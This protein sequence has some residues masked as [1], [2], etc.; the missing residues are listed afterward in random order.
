MAKNDFD[1]DWDDPFG[2]EFDLDMD[3][4]MDPYAKKGFLGGV[5]SGFLSGVVDETVGSGPARMRTL[6]TI[7]PS[8]FSNALDR[9]SYAATK[10]EE[11]KTDFKE[12]NYESVKSLQS[13]ARSIGEKARNKG[14]GK[15]ADQLD[16]FSEKDFSSWEKYDY[17]SGPTVPTMEQTDEY[18]VSR[19]IEESMDSQEGVMFRLGDS[20][21]E[22]SATV[23]GMLNGAIG[24]GNRQLVS[25]DSGVKQLI[26]FQRSIQFKMDQAKVNLM[27]K[28]YVADIKFYKFMEKG[29][30]TEIS[31]LKKIVINSNKSDYEKTSHLTASKAFMRNRLFNT[32]G[33]RVGGLSGLL[34]DRFGAD[35]RKGTYGDIEGILGSFAEVLEMSDDMPI[36]KGMLG[37]M[38]GKHLAGALINN[39]PYYFERGGGKEWIDKLAEKNPE[40]AEAFKERYSQV[41]NA[42]NKI[43]YMANNATGLFNYMAED[44]QPI[45]EMKYLDYED[46]LD[47]LPADKK[48]TPR[49]LWE[50]QNAVGNRAKAGINN[51][52]AEMTKAKGT[53][54]TLARRNVKDLNQPG[55]WKEMN[56]IT[57]NEVLPGLLGRIHQSVEGIRTGE[58]GEAISYSYMRGQYMEEGDRKTAVAADL[59]PYSDFSRY[60]SAALEFVDSVDPDKLL[61]ANARKAFA[62]QIAKDVDKEKGFN[63]FYYLG[64]IPGITGSVQNEIHTVIKRHFD[65]DDDG[66]EAFKQ[67]TGLDRVNFM[68]TMKTDIAQERLNQAGA[69]AQ[70]LKEIFPNVAERIDLLRSTGNEQL[71]RDIGV[72]Y[73]ENGVD[74]V[75]MDVFHNR[76]AQFMDNP[77]DPA[78]RGMGKN[79]TF[80]QKGKDFT[81]T[82]FTPKPNPYTEVENNSSVGITG[83]LNT[84]MAKLIDTINKMDKSITT[85]NV[86][87]LPNLSEYVTPLSNHLDTISSNTGK[88]ESLMV[89][90]LDIVKAGKLFS[91][92]QS[93]TEEK[94]EESAKSGFMNKMKQFLPTNIF[95]KGLDLVMKNQPIVLG[96]V[97]GA[98]G[99]NF[100]NNP[101]LAAGAIAGGALLGAVVQRW[102]KQDRQA[103]GDQPS[104]D[105][106]ILNEK[107]ETL[108]SSA[109]LKAGL[110]IDA[111]TKRV[112]NTW[113]EIR[114]PIFDT[115]EKIV[116]GIKDLAGKIFGA[117]G[118]AVVLNG[119]RQLKEA[120]IAAYNFVDPIGRIKS[121]MAM[122]KELIYQQ[123]VYVPGDKNPRLRAI[124]FKNRDYF[125]DDAGSYRPISGWNE[126]KGPV[127]D[128]EANELISQEEY[129]A[130]LITASGQKVRTVSAFAANTMSGVAGLA[131]TGFE[132]LMAKMGFQRPQ[133]QENPEGNK[134]GSKTSQMAGTEHRLDRIYALLSKQFGKG[135]DNDEI[136]SGLKGSFADRL[137]SLADKAAKAKE[138]KQ[139]K[140]NEAIQDIAAELKGDDK[141]PGEEKKQGLFSKLLGMFGSMGG[142]AM[143]FIRNPLGTLAGGILGSL[144]ASAG[145]LG[146]IGSLLF[147]GVLGIASPIFKLL[148]WGFTG[149]AKVISAS[150]MGG[151]GSLLGTGGGRGRGGILGGLGRQLMKLPTWGKVAGAAALA[152]GSVYAGSNLF[153]SEEEAEAD[154]FATESE[155]EPKPYYE[156]PKTGAEQAYLERQ[157]A[158]ETRDKENNESSLGSVGK[159]IADI[160]P[161]NWLAKKALGLFGMDV[162]KEQG[163]K[164]FS[165]DGKMFLSKQDRDT[166]E[167]QRDGV[168]APSSLTRDAKGTFSIQKQIRYA[169]YGLRKVDNNLAMRIDQLEQN[170]IPYVSIINNRGAFRDDAPVEKIV[171]QFAMGAG[172]ISYDQ[173]KTWFSARFKPIFLIYNVGISIAR[174]GDINEFDMSTSPDV[175]ATIDRLRTSVTTVEPFPLKVSVQIDPDTGIM[176]EYATN[177]RVQELMEELRKKF[178][179]DK[180]TLKL[181]TADEMRKKALSSEPRSSNPIVGAVQ[182]FFGRTAMEDQQRLLDEKFKTPKEVKE[183]DIS[184]LHS[185]TD[186]AMDPFTWARLS[187]YGNVDN[188]PWRVDAVLKLERYTENLYAVM[189]E[190]IKF[191]GHPKKVLELF[192]PMFRIEDP[193]AEDR[194]LDW[195][196]NRFLPVVSVY[197]KRCQLYRSGK[198]SRVWQQLSATNKVVIAR[199]L[200]EIRVFYNDNEVSIWDVTVGPFPNSVSGNAS[201][202]AEKFLKM[203]DIKATE[204]RLKEPEVEE[205]KSKTASERMATTKPNS[206][207][208]K[209]NTNR[210]FDRVYGTNRQ[211]ASG[212][213]S[214]GGGGSGMAM[215][216]NGSPSASNWSQSLGDQ[217]GGQFDGKWAAGFN[218]EYAKLAGEDK[219]IKFDPAEGERL[220]LNTMLK[221]GITDKKQIAL[222]LAMAKKETGNY[223]A[224]VENT[225]W[226]A[227]TLKK[228]FRNIPDM[229]TAQ[230]V[231]SLPPAERAMY[232]YGRAPKGPTLGNEKPEDGW[233]YRGRGLF[234]LTGKANYR[235][236][237]SETG[238]PVVEDP[239]LVSENPEVMAESAVRFL[240]N[241]KAMMDIG[242]SGNFETAVRGIN[243]GNAVPGTDERRQY[244][245]E[246]LQK[247]NSG[248]LSVPLTV[249]TQG[250]L[251]TPET[252]PS[253]P[254]NVT[255]G[256]TL[257]G[258]NP[259]SKDKLSEQLNAA[260]TTR[261]VSTAPSESGNKKTSAAV[262]NVKDIVEASDKP[263]KSE[264]KLPA[265]ATPAP[266]VPSTMAPPPAIAKPQGPTEVTLPEG[267]LNVKDEHM[268]GVM[269]SVVQTLDSLNK[270]LGQFN[271]NNN[272]VAL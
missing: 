271:R 74:K 133:S 201:S 98:V 97:L 203:L 142:L 192:K 83:E 137:N 269:T 108:L 130:G 73:T 169:Q 59:M 197:I 111:I 54:Y 149:L 211:I 167:D 183:I 170:L 165:D 37:S 25:I 231:A 84:T 92:K 223:S 245:Q 238:I 247:L 78:L 272:G 86:S 105:E 69:S 15:T 107:G 128:S 220:M 182:D 67:T 30:H 42:G 209:N 3:F 120:G 138:E 216:A 114:G 248:E 20:L 129:D 61:S 101:I 253:A 207:T 6:R 191:I 47:N 62:L 35:A 31:E 242:R 193:H 116:I 22:M 34:R 252:P 10:Y 71:L 94:Q 255:D 199:E 159:V 141:E 166:Y 260:D 196:E 11:L 205:E 33:N 229:A 180:S 249:E 230:K 262:P 226:S 5:T 76:F 265:V 135:V 225:N 152:G 208:I 122:G 90:L 49:A 173:A 91:R 251:E 206:D 81:G 48:P 161:Q 96:S 8:S 237:Q 136:D 24:A 100:I 239:K 19:S 12:Q 77:N 38:A 124:G 160:V 177:D 51:V 267:P 17:N 215:G 154:P 127:F 186:A 43:S 261:N 7:L 270:T 117:D 195:F 36:S 187:V 233:L 109:K 2:G 174:L 89:E 4:D 184:D 145:R 88:M 146:K 44:W 241:S 257:G 155:K 50:I 99:A 139:D 235:K 125:I 140:T 132:T 95:G 16:N 72:I 56:N 110:Y 181:P 227:P 250:D 102:E 75:N 32:V 52:M 45:D 158:R 168:I 194:W 63:P 27:A 214:I 60:T 93:A 147:S 46:Y 79:Q 123:D 222:G 14:F 87:E 1:M 115:V 157:T 156:P 202:R 66:V 131:K 190:E 171:K 126:I 179:E 118:R 246:Y 178:P 219:G 13:I 153:S 256:G 217:K 57:L 243:G 39:A 176:G 55:I 103:T 80:K 212:N 144:G 82:P 70:N 175:R 163:G 18:D 164:I 218:P 106:D 236:F 213:V 244:Y 259:K 29:I 85:P 204:A 172:N 185:S 268:A 53:Q 188:M 64:D 234:Q 104:D 200:A 21:N 254:D 162:E 112:V 151:L 263:T 26:D 28:S 113:S 41:T 210:L 266:Q 224:T 148:K 150:A 68:S 143:K 232:V 23:G 240:K 40:Q 221:H 121:I 189:G 9:V 134:E 58:M 228:L 198:P 258:D 65:I 119:L 264:S